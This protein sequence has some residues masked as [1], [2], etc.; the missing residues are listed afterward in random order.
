MRRLTAAALAAACITLPAMPAHALPMQRCP[1]YE[2]LLTAY[3][4]A[5]GWSVPRMSYIAWR[6]SRCRPVR[7]VT[8]DSGVWQINDINIAY[9]SRVFGVRV[10]PA[11]LMDPTNNVRAAAAL[12]NYWRRVN[13]N[14]YHAWGF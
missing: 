5:G 13:G 10:T 12:C 1:Q 9:L 8:S 3:A 2:R 6:E 7:S 4:P 11:W 14:C